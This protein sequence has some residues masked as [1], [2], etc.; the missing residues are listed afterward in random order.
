MSRGR[1]PTTGGSRTRAWRTSRSSGRALPSLANVPDP[2]PHTSALAV[3]RNLVEFLRET[4][5]PG[6]HADVAI[7]NELQAVIVFI[8]GD[9]VLQCSFEE[10][11][12]RRY[13]CN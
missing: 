7:N 2:V 9:P 11:V 4:L 3:S 8:E 10:L 5:R 1:G 6:Q 12:T 13:V